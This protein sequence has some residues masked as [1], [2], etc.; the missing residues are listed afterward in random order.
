MSV[1]A[2]WL[3]AADRSACQLKPLYMLNSQTTTKLSRVLKPITTGSAALVL[4]CNFIF[5]PDKPDF[6]PGYTITNVQ[7][8]IIQRNLENPG[9]LSY[10]T[11][12]LNLASYL[13]LKSLGTPSY[14]YSTTNNSSNT[15]LI[16][17]T[18]LFSTG[19]LFK[20]SRETDR[21]EGFL[22]PAVYAFQGSVDLLSNNPPLN[23]ILE[24][25]L[26]TYFSDFTTGT[27]RWRQDDIL[28][29][30]GNIAD[31]VFTN[32]GIFCSANTSNK[33]FEIGLDGPSVFIENN[34]LFGITD[35]IFA[36]DGKIYAAQAPRVKV[37]SI[38]NYI[39]HLSITRPKRVI[40]IDLTTKTIT[41]EFELPT[42]K[43]I[44]PK[45]PEDNR[46]NSK[47]FL[48]DERIKIVENSVNGKNVLGIDFYVSDMFKE[49]IYKVTNKKVEVLKDSVNLPTSLA[50]DSTGNLFYTS[51]PLWDYP[52]LYWVSPTKIYMLNPATLEEKVVYNFGEEQDYEIL[53]ALKV[54]N[55]RYITQTG[56]NITN[57]LLE[58]GDNLI[59]IFTNSHAKD[60]RVIRGQK[61][62]IQ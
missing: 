51:S 44:H 16:N 29:P 25:P 13:N 46:L 26:S 60:I 6:N 33:L 62:K 5:G 30:I 21:T 3:S 38:V 57:V 36:R 4:G 12:N 40:S 10:N 17:Y 18:A 41:Q 31:I 2:K 47:G 23:K 15:S 55:G 45:S 8:K 27:F 28:R 1:A 61:S 7:E 48:A 53:S 19:P 22:N 52:I 35:M 49:V 43:E 14:D 42:E 58:D 34:E 50:V 37:D 9:G 59:F 32:K 24:F 56:V 39:T 11:D 54:K 20:H